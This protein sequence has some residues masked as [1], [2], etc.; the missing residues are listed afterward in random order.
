MS[1]L[2]G[3]QLTHP[4]LAQIIFC[5]PSGSLCGMSAFLSLSRHY[6]IIHPCT[7]L[8]LFCGESFVIVT[9]ST[10]LT[11]IALLHVWAI[12]LIMVVWCISTPEA[13]LCL[14]SGFCKVALKVLLNCHWCMPNVLHVLHDYS[15]HLHH[16][17]SIWLPSVVFT[18]AFNNHPMHLLTPIF[19]WDFYCRSWRK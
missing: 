7:I 8:L 14:C 10:T 2:W 15:A 9:V 3:L 4:D 17:H 1:S 16:W 19:H 11:I 18:V 5:L 6:G 12:R 13:G